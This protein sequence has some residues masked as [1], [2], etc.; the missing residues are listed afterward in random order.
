MNFP[1]N[2]KY[3]STHEWIQDMGGGKI[4]IG[5]SDYA[6]D[7]LGDLVYVTLPEEGDELVKGKAFADVE[8][9]KAVADVMSPVS[10]TVSA[11]NTDLQD[12]PEMMNEDPYGAW[13]VEVEGASEAE[14]TM[15]ADEYKEFC[16]KEQAK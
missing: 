7:Q 14:D 11:I 8:S 9:V 10:G 16:E 1:E 12:S 13:F 5:I 6:Q 3:T 2:L 4:R 15:S